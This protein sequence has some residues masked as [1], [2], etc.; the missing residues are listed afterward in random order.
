VGRHKD[1]SAGGDEELGLLMAADG[2]C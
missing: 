1:A 2:A